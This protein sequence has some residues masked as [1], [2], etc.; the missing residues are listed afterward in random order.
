MKP[1]TKHG[2]THALPKAQPG[3]VAFTLTE[4]LFVLVT[5]P[6]PTLAEH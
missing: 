5:K 1:Q 6:S 2:T 4:L 3:R